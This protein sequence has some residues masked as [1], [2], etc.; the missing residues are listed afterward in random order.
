MSIEKRTIEQAPDGSYISNTLTIVYED[1]DGHN[2]TFLLDPDGV[3][4]TVLTNM[5]KMSQP[6]GSEGETLDAEMLATRNRVQALMRTTIKGALIA[7]G[8]MLLKLF[9]PKDSVPKVPKEKHL[10]LIDWYTQRFAEVFISNMLRQELVLSGEY[11]KDML[12]V[13]KIDEVHTRP[14]AAPPTIAAE[15]ASDTE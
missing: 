5:R 14:V 12:D 3:Y 15:T 2:I 7:F 1:M 9:Y 6:G 13:I 4:L 10:D 11:M 8:P